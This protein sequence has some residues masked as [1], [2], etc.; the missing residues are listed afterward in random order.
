MKV[1][2]AQLHVLGFRFVREIVKTRRFI[3]SIG[4]ETIDQYIQ[5]LEDARRKASSDEEALQYEYLVDNMRAFRKYMDDV[6]SI[7]SYAKKRGMAVA[8][9]GTAE[10]IVTRGVAPGS[11]IKQ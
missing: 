10:I 4:A 1:D 6:A 8:D 2:N 5:A 9:T 7:D 11:D 3:D